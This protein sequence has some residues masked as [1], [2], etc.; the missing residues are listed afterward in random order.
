M[1][2]FLTSRVLSFSDAVSDVGTV[3]KYPLGTKRDQDGVTYRYCKRNDSTVAFAAG[4][5]V[6]HQA[7]T[8]GAFWT[9]SGDVSDV[10][11]AFTAGIAQ[12]SIADGGFGWILTRG[13]VSNLKKKTG[14]TGFRYVKGDFL[15]ASAAA[16]DD[17]RAQRFV[18][19][20]S[21]LT[22]GALR[23]QVMTSVRKVMERPIGW[24]ITAATKAATSG[25]A[26]IDLE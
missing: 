3:Q 26:F 7:T 10:D 12:G 19:L 20:I 21:T 24:A 13:I 6:Y 22:L 25:V 17:G 23:A 8:I 2:N 14:T 18:G 15:I 9:V 16:T 5:V 11:P 1:A 4:D